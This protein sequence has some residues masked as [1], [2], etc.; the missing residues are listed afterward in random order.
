[1]NLGHLSGLDKIPSFYMRFLLG[2]MI[3]M[4]RTLAHAH[5]HGLVHGRYN[6]TKVLVQH[7]V[8][9]ER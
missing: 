1:M 2:Y 3:Q 6:L 4:S 8:L 7:Q 9:D 5:R